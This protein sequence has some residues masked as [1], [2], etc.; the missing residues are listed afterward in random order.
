MSNQPEHVPTI[1]ETVQLGIE[2][3]NEAITD[4]RQGRYVLAGSGLVLMVVAIF[5]FCLYVLCMLLLRIPFWL[6][7]YLLARLSARPPIE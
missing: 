1:S 3:W 6:I 4:A 7:G 2:A 5:F